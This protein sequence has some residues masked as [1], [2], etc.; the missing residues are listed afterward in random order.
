MPQLF[1][2]FLFSSI[3]YFRVSDTLIFRLN[4]TT[5]A[6][7]D[8]RIFEYYVTGIYLGRDLISDE[9]SIIDSCIGDLD[10]D[11]ISEEIYLLERPF[12]DWP[13]AKWHDERTPIAQNRDERGFSCSIFVFGRKSE[14]EKTKLLWA[15]S[16]MFIP[17]NEIELIPGEGVITALE[18]D[19]TCWKEKSSV[20][21]LWKWSGFGFYRFC[22]IQTGLDLRELK[23]ISSEDEF[24]IKVFS[25]CEN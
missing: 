7:K 23:I 14:E 22:G 16:P 2:L 12:R 6:L 21:A 5:D 11:G 13:I 10:G 17:F 4:D 15:G 24:I 25:A 20:I 3:E 18:S 1:V 8:V 19:Y 9:Y